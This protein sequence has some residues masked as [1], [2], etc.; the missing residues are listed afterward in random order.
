MCFSLDITIWDNNAERIVE[1]ERN[2]TVALHRLGM[3]GTVR[4]MSEPP[5][6][7]REGLLNDVPVLEIGENYWKLRPNQVITEEQCLS[8]LRRFLS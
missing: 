3:R 5:L 4:S 2:L 8:L 7:G 6:L 1:I